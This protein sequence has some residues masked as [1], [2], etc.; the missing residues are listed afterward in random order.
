MPDE[1]KQHKIRR[2]RRPRSNAGN[3]ELRARESLAP[4]AMDHCAFGVFRSRLLEPF[5]PVPARSVPTRPG[6]V[7]SVVELDSPCSFVPV[8]PG[9]PLR[10]APGPIIPFFFFP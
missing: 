8:S 1:W 5:Q 3:F 10:L 9:F 7:P 4:P 2:P 6:S